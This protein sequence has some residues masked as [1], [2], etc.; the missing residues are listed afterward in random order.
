[1]QEKPF[2]KKDRADEIAMQYGYEEEEK[3]PEEEE[4]SWL[5]QLM[6]FKN[7]NKKQQLTKVSQ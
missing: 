3:K 5:Q 2:T 7:R 4:K 6:E 1:M